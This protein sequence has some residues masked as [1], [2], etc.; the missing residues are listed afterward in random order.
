MNDFI[1]KLGPSMN[2][3]LEFKHALGIKYETASAYLHELDRYNAA[4][5]NHRT[6]V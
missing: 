2:D 5:G 4:H 6:L 3:F 1:S